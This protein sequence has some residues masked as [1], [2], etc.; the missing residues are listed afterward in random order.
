MAYRTSH[1]YLMCP[2]NIF[3]SSF[4]K[5]Y[6][7]TDQ[8]ILH[9]VTGLPCF[10]KS[11][12]KKHKNNLSKLVFPFN[13]HNG[14]GNL[15]FYRYYQFCF[16]AKGWINK[17]QSLQDPLFLLTLLWNLVLLAS[18]PTKAFFPMYLCLYSLRRKLSKKSLKNRL[19]LYTLCRK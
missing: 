1:E 15:S 11:Q 10:L 7:C 2:L 17:S 16:D 6:H 18:V 9:R 13:L 19:P 4:Q 3:V 14:K 5:N 8:W 12:F